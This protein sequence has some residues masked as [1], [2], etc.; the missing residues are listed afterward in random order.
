MGTA[1]CLAG[2][3]VKDFD[4]YDISEGLLEHPTDDS[5]NLISGELEKLEGC[6]IFYNRVKHRWI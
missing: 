1:M 3:I 6:Y 4:T 2:H 5:F